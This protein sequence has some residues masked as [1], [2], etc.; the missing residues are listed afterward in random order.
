MS[1][2]LCVREHV[3]FQVMFPDERS[4]TQVTLELL[5]ASM[6]EHMRRHMGFLGKQ[7]LANCAS[8]VLL[9]CCE[10][11]EKEFLRLQMFENKC[12]TFRAIHFFTFLY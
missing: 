2:L 12:L 11:K 1:Y 10:G 7:L 6:D 4:V 9:T 8:V 5:C 3:L